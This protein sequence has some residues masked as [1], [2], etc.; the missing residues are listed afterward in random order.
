[1]KS[2]IRTVLSLSRVT[3]GL[4]FCVVCF[5]GCQQPPERI[6]TE[7]E[8]APRGVSTRTIGHSAL[9]KPI[10]CWTMGSG[11]STVLIIASIHGDEPAGTP[12]VRELAD[13]LTSQPN[14]LVG[15]R[16]V[17]VPVANPD[18][19]AKGI[20]HN[21]RGVDLNRNYPASNYR[22]GNVHGSAPL[23]EP[24]S[25]AI[26]KLL[27]AHRPASIVSF[28]QPTRAGQA[29][30]DYDGPAKSLADAMAAQ[31]DLPVQRIGSRPGSL[32]SFAGIT[33]KVP[34]IT[35]ELPKEATD[36]KPA[37]LWR[38]Y[39]RMLIAMIRY[40]EPMSASAD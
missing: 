22:N 28:H 9:G 23:S 13:H 37:E 12:L 30:I 24:E 38:R 39:G 29:C 8:A 6:E 27:T 10:T 40:P 31:C 1:M 34:I 2:A 4:L 11:P 14:L 25:V 26:H 19:Y 18:G 35:V 3:S 16:V 36:W 33:M 21:A 5:G 7:R 15:R 20:R 17:I 32:G